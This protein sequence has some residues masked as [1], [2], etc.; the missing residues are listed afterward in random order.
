[1][2]DQQGGPVP[3]KGKLRQKRSEAGKKCLN[4]RNLL[5]DEL[6]YTYGSE[7]YLETIFFLHE[8][9]S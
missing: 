5:K 4:L 8:A 2:W 7:K 9:V 1:M 6:L 3:M